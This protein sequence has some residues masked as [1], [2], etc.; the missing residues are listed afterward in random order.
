MNLFLK[1]QPRKWHS[2]PLHKAFAQEVT[3]ISLFQWK[4]WTC[5]WVNNFI[6]ILS[7][8]NTSLV[9][10]TPNHL[11]DNA[12]TNSIHLSSHILLK[13]QRR[14][15]PRMQMDTLFQGAM[16]FSVPGGVLCPSWEHYSIERTTMISRA[17]V[18]GVFPSFSD[19]RKLHIVDPCV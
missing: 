6:G 11:G 19:E 13:P 8:L 4:P 15:R 12:Y 3:G 2:Q 18:K 1:N 10:H 14:Y 5:K 9:S 7:L 16:L 17:S